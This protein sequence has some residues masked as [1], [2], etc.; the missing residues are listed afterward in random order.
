MSGIRPA[1]VAGSFYPAEP[2]ELHRQLGA[3]LNQASTRPPARAAIPKAIIVPHAGYVYSGPIAASAYVLL[4]PVRGMV[5]RVVLIGPSHW[6]AFQGLAVGTADAWQTPL[7]TV[8]VD[9]DAVERLRRLPAVVTA[10]SAHVREHALEVHVPFL[11]DVLGAFRL[12]PIV[13]GDTSPEM[14]AEALDAVWGG[15]ETLVVV[16]SDLS[17]YLD[18]RSCQDA[19]RRTAAAIQALDPGAIDRHGA[20]GRVPVGG[21]LLTAQRRGMTVVPL[22]LRNSGDTAGPKDRVV[23]YGSWAF[24]E[25]P[26]AERAPAEDAEETVRAVG[27]TL[28]ALARASIE[29]GL[30]TGRPAPAPTTQDMQETLRKPGAAFVTLMRRG[31]LRG[32]IGSAAAW[33]PLAEDVTDNAFRAAFRDSRFVPLAPREADGLEVSVSVLTAPEPMTFADESALLEQLTPGVDGLIIEDGHCRALFLPA[34]WAQLPNPRGFLDHLK[35]KAGLD[36]GHWSPAFRA[37]R[38]RAIEVKG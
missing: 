5:E 24:Y 3:L 22:D 2:A 25:H 4:A 17:H 36:A 11:Q 1:S 12:I 7:G 33:R 26:A 20:C 10:D 21:L 29:C 27:P 32:C 37:S 28:I 35:R 16:S 9:G 6:V 13:A 38:F 30:A 18:Y 19:D 15:P 23:G 31:G 8:P 14:V 34:V